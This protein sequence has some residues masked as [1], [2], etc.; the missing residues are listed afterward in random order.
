M[1]TGPTPGLRRFHAF[2]ALLA[3]LPLM[4]VGIT[5][6]LLNHQ[7]ALGLDRVAAE[8]IAGWTD[9][10]ERPLRI[11]TALPAQDGWI[12]GTKQGVFA[13]RQ[14]TRELLLGGVDAR[15]IRPWGSELLVASKQGLWASAHGRWLKLAEGDIHD[16]I[17]DEAGRLWLVTHDGLS[18]SEDDGGSWHPVEEPARALAGLRE[19]RPATLK[20]LIHDLHTGRAIV[21]AK[22]AWLWVD[23]ISA[24]MMLTGLIGIWMWWRRRT[25]M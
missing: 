6:M 17:I 20:H 16:V 18:V 3:F 23:L 22:R 21:G 4:L 13:I 19:R 9:G 1:Y 11:K 7:H 25:V 2:L 10:R 12:V 24:L 15:A 5:A 14:G 8:W